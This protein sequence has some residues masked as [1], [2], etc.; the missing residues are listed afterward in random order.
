MRVVMLGPP[1]SGK[2]THGALVAGALGVPHIS[3]SDLLRQHLQGRTATG[4]DAQNTMAA[5][6]LVDDDVMVRLVLERLAEADAEPGFVLDGFPRNVAQAA[7]LDDWLA[8]RGC[9]L[10]AVVLLEVSRDVL[11]QRL[12]ERNVSEGR[13]DDDAPTI[14]HRLAVYETQ[15]VPLIEYYARQGVLRRVDGDGSVRAVA[16]R[17]LAALRGSGRP[18]PS[19]EH[20]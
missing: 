8:E 6:D 17:I 9:S 7:A 10:D 1:G 16:E 20:P 12:G 13:A 19:S 11:L 4:H 18:P 2:G 3:S 5:G 14:A 15:T